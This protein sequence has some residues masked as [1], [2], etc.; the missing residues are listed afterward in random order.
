M[1]NTHERH[2][3]NLRGLE[4]LRA[5]VEGGSLNDAANR[6]CRTQPQVSRLLSALEEE[7]GIALFDRSKR[8][9]T[10][11]E[12]AREFYAHVEHALYGLDDLA[13]AARRFRNGNRRHLR[14]LSA[15][16]VTGALLTPAI[17][18]MMNEDPG[19][20]AFVESRPRLD[21]EIWLAKQSFDIG[22]T[23][24][25]VQHVGMDLEPIVTVPCVAVMSADHT[26]AHKAVL[27]VEDLIDM[28]L[29]ATPSRTIIRQ[30]VERVFGEVSRRPMI[31]LEASNGVVACEM[32]A[33]GLGIAMAD[34]FVAQSCM[35]PAKVLRRFDPALN[36]PYVFLL[37][38]SQPRTPTVRRLMDL[39][40][41]I[42]EDRLIGWNCDGLPLTQYS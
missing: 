38:K 12:E 4:A 40:R 2:T 14:I 19:F 9:L 24:P 10:L 8:R 30:H 21:I 13:E 39:V 6:M 42:A 15:P 34:G 5:Y 7:V 16:N 28:P 23:A 31:R 27:H 25:A 20:T 33:E 32:A 1:R 29:I 26:L 3:V 41:Q 17:R 37:P 35:H 22:I 18:T 11:T 36:V